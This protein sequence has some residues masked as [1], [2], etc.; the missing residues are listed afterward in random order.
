VFLQP[1]M[2]GNNFLIP[3]QG[4]LFS[5]KIILNLRLPEMERFR[6]YSPFL[7]QFSFEFELFHFCILLLVGMVPYKVLIVSGEFRVYLITL[8][9]QP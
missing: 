2:L 5:P 3:T 7:I 9:L 6:R 1:I 8:G 4:R